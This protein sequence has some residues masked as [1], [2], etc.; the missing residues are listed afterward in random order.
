MSEDGFE[1]APD[2]TVR[3]SG[4]KSYIE[5]NLVE[6]YIQV[7][8][9]K[10]RDEDGG[11]W[12]VECEHA[13]DLDVQDFADMIISVWRSGVFL[14]GTERMGSHPLWEHVLNALNFD[15]EPT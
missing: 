15:F 3:Y 5:V 1:K 7:I 14:P 2:F 6:G 11:S 13:P 10:S 4:T 9:N 8:T 12:A